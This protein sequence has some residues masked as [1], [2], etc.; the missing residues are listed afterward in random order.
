MVCMYLTQQK[1]WMYF[2]FI[3]CV[4]SERYLSAFLTAIVI[5]SCC[6]RPVAREARSILC[7]SSVSGSSTVIVC[8]PIV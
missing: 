6:L 4:H 5:V 1:F 7:I 2:S 3:F 8:V